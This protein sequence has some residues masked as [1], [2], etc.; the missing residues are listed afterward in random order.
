MDSNIQ[1]WSGGLEKA[2]LDIRNV[3]ILNEFAIQSVD[4]KYF[5]INIDNGR[6]QFETPYGYFH[7][8][9]Q[10]T[11]M[12]SDVGDSMKNANYNI[13]V[14]FLIGEI[15]GT[16]IIEKPILIACNNYGPKDGHHILLQATEKELKIEKGWNNGRNDKKS[17]VQ[18][19]S[20]D[21]I[22]GLQHK[23]QEQLDFRNR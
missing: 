6:L 13:H 15:K 2:N 10:K 3:V 20:I 19:S 16:I 11:N 4:L 12:E 22:R 17:T 8:F 5:K 1:L 21:S 7:M 18:Q 14:L 9:M 23:D